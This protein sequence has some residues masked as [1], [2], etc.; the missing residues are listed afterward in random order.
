VLIDQRAR[1]RLPAALPL[2]LTSVCG[3]EEGRVP[4]AQSKTDVGII[5][6]ATYPREVILWA[7]AHNP[8]L[9]WTPQGLATW[10]GLRL[11]DV[12]EVL[13]DLSTRGLLRSTGR[14]EPPRRDDLGNPITIHLWT[15]GTQPSRAVA[16]Q[17][18]SRVA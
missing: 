12:R 5:G 17:D 10:F 4:R 13:A 7:F 6:E 18:I 2:M 3:T 14:E 8:N 11:P 16:E 1:I 15:G 9:P